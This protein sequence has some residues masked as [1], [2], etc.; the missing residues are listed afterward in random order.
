MERT[1]TFDELSVRNGI[2]PGLVSWSKARIENLEGAS[3]GSAL[4]TGSLGHTSPAGSLPDTE[5]TAL[6]DEIEATDTQPSKRRNTVRSRIYQKRKRQEARAALKEEAEAEEAA[7]R[8]SMNQPTDSTSINDD[9]SQGDDQHSKSAFE[10]EAAPTADEWE[11]GDSSVE[12]HDDV[13]A[14]G[15]LESEL[16]EAVENVWAALLTI[17]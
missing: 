10:K 15:G 1:P 13:V 14:G 12:N 2:S 11:I 5:S 16:C 9:G 8:S 7:S 3:H 17:I 6:G 4:A